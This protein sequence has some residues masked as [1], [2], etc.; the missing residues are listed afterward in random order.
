MLFPLWIH[1]QTLSGSYSIYKKELYIDFEADLK[2]FRVVPGI[3]LLN[4]NKSTLISPYLRLY[5]DNNINIDLSY[6]YSSYNYLF[7]LNNYFVV[8]FQGQYY[9]I[10]KSVAI[11]INLGYKFNF[12]KQSTND[13]K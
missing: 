6:L 1:N 13:K 8:N 5:L 9:Y 3:V 2:P 12:Y 11:R 7:Y 4:S 10:D